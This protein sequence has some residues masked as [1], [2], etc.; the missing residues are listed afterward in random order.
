MSEICKIQIIRT[1]F[2]DNTTIGKLYINEI[3]FCWTLEDAVRGYGIKVD[4]HTAITK[5]IYKGK[6][7]K[8]HRFKRLMMMIFTEDNGYEI[9]KGGISFK[10]VRL[11]GGNSHENTEACV[12]IAHKRISSKIIQGSA[13]KAFLE[14]VKDFDEFEIQIIN[15]YHKLD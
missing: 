1:E 4:K 12:L 14:A 13:E 3:E 10:G 15:D 2:F 7:S 11:H 8:S 6:I 5:G 9:K